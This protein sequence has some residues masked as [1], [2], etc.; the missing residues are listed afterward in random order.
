MPSN[1][2]HN[3]ETHYLVEICCFL[4]YFQPTSEKYNSNVSGHSISPLVNDFCEHHSDRFRDCYCEHHRDTK[5]IGIPKMTV[6][7]KT[8]T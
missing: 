4:K 7:E 1:E 3:V 2:S 5:Q 8:R 6:P